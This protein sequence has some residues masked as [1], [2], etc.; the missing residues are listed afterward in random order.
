MEK[1]FTTMNAT[2]QTAPHVAFNLDPE[3]ERTYNANDPA[4]DSL[5]QSILAEGIKVPLH[6]YDDMT[7]A[8]GNRRLFNIGLAIHSGDWP[9]DRPIPYL[10]V[11]RPANQAEGV[12][13]RLNENEARQFTATEQGRAFVKLR[14]AGL[15]NVQI[16]ARTPFSSMHIGNMLTLADAPTSVKDAVENGGMS[17]TLAVE[18]L[19]AHGE[20]VLLAAVALANDSGKAKATQRHVD[21]ILASRTMTKPAVPTPNTA[22]DDDQPTDFDAPDDDAP[23]D[24]VDATDDSPVTPSDDP[25][26]DADDAPVVDA[27]EIDEG[28]DYVDA[29]EADT[30]Q[31][32]APVVEAET[33]VESST[34]PAQS[35]RALLTDILPT[36]EDLLDAART[37]DAETR[38]AVLR[39]ARSDLERLITAAKVQ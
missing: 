26:F 20:G 8:S 2:V 37:G 33:L 4:N 23:V 32:D 16:S 17:A 34:K 38:A 24:V 14:A 15:N 11:P 27:D 35:L 25:P 6:V 9:T 28:T 13:R 29:A 3:N 30:T 31:P 1:D 5:R 12:I 36:L 7:V 22:D 39:D 19:R 10:V 21:A 18:V